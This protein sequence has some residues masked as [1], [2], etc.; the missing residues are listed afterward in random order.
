MI[1]GN[2][3]LGRQR[4]RDRDVQ[5]LDRGAQRVGRL[6]ADDA[7]AGEQ[8]RPLGLRDHVGDA[9]D[10]V[11]VGAHAAGGRAACCRR[12]DRALH[13][14]QLDVVGQL[15]E[16]R[17]RAARGRDLHRGVEHLDD[18]VGPDDHPGA[19]RHRLEHRGRVLEAV[20]ENLLH[21]G[22]AHEMGGAAAGD[23]Q[24]RGGIVHGARRSADRIEQARALVDQHRR[25]LAG[26][27]VVHVGHVHGMRLVLGLDAVEGVKLGGQRVQER[28]D[29]APGITEIFVV[30][31]DFEPLGDRID[32]PHGWPPY[33]CDV[34]SRIIRN[35]IR[36]CQR[37][38]LVRRDS[39]VP[40][41]TCRQVP[42]AT[43]FDRHD[44][45]RNVYCRRSAA[46]AVIGRR[47]RTALPRG[48]S[49]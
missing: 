43:M 29:R 2:L 4:G 35:K 12:L 45:R 46:C 38:P 44:L 3:A 14:G 48:G 37:Q 9:L 16:H 18:A 24:H 34:A 31:G 33:C 6:R 32:D 21:A 23:D 17:P 49:L 20:I 26:H 22:L 41:A 42:M 27:A 19:L 5:L 11:L 10:G 39:S 28:P 8:Q 40:V 13:L 7:A 25:D 30:S 15:H 36:C 47:E 1:L